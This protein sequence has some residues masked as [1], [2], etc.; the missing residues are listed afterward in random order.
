MNDI[1]IEKETAFEYMERRKTERKE[2]RQKAFE[3]AQR[4][5][6][7]AM[8]NGGSMYHSM[9]IQPSDEDIARRDI[10]DKISDIVAYMEALRKKFME[11]TA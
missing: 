2:E 11:K 7:E 3:E 9:P 8:S 5:K 6:F 10:Q 4:R 1:L